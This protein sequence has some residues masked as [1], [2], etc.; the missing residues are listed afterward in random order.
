MDNLE[1]TFKRDYEKKLTDM[2]ER[3]GI[4]LT[5]KNEEIAFMQE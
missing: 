1:Y 4:R 5:E 2:Q 3:L